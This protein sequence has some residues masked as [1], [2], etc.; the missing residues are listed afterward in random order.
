MANTIGTP[1][2]VH[3]GGPAQ[4]SSLF[5]VAITFSATISDQDSVSA[6]DTAAFALTVPGAALGDI[7]LVGINNDMSDGTDQAVLYGVVSAADTVSVRVN[8]DVGAYAADD[9]NGAVVKGVCLR[10]TW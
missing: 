9:L 3:R 4:W 7:V 2:V 6:G 8:A 10:P 1:L 5:N